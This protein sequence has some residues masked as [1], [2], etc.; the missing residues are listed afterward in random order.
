MRVKSTVIAA[1]F[2]LLVSVAPMLAHHSFAAEYDANKPIKITGLVTKLE[3][4]NPHA[5]FYVDVKDTDGKVTNWN[6]ELGAIPVLLKQGWRKDSLKVGDQVTVEG[7]MA[8]DGANNANARRVVLP[9]GRRVFA[10]SAGADA[11]PNQ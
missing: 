8:K 5:R 2:G 7:L 1:G 3:W 9:D 6:F 10:G 11:P 4:M